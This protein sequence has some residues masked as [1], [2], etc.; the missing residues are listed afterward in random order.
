MLEDALKGAIFSRTTESTHIRMAGSFKLSSQD[1]QFI[2]NYRN[3][4]N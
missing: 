4:Y 1:K 2:D 3:A